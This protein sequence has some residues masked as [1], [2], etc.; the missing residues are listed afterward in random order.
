MI[1]GSSLIVHNILYCFCKYIFWR[2]FFSKLYINTINKTSQI[3]TGRVLCCTAETL[4]WC[5][6]RRNIS[7]ILE[8][9]KLIIQ[10]GFFSV[11]H[12]TYRRQLFYVTINV[13]YPLQVD[14]HYYFTI[15]SE[16]FKIIPIKYFVIGKTGPPF[17]KTNS[18]CC[19]WTCTFKLLL[20]WAKVYMYLMIG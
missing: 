12:K 8:E 20:S 4:D 13:I 11:N 16:Q 7:S 19:I 15:I 2:G 10:C 17:P 6:A 5:F 3:Y 1:F 18:R 9:F 14:R